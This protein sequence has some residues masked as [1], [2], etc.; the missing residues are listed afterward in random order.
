LIKPGGV[1]IGDKEFDSLDDAIQ[2]ADKYDAII[3]Y[4]NIQSTDS[5]ST[6]GRYIRVPFNIEKIIRF[7]VKLKNRIKSV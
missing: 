7:F 4:S 1:Y 5:F 3:V 6:D 2:A